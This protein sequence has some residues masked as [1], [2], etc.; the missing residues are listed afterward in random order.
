MAGALFF[1]RLLEDG[2]L[3]VEIAGKNKIY[4][5]YATCKN[6]FNRSF[7][8]VHKEEKSDKFYIPN[9]AGVVGYYNKGRNFYRNSLPLGVFSPTALDIT[10]KNKHIRLH[11]AC[12]IQSFINRGRNY[13]ESFSVLNVHDT[14]LIWLDFDKQHRD[15]V[16][17]QLKA[18]KDHV[19]SDID[20]KVEGSMSGNGAHVWFLAD[21][22][23][24]PYEKIYA[25]NEEEGTSKYKQT[26]R[27]KYLNALTTKIIDDLEK[28]IP[29]LK[30]DRR[31][32]KSHVAFCR[33]EV[34]S[35]NAH[36]KDK[37][38]QP[39]IFKNEVENPELLK[40]ED[41]EQLGL[42]AQI[43]IEETIKTK[44]ENYK[45]YVTKK[46]DT[47]FAEFSR[48]LDSDLFVLS[49]EI[50]DYSVCFLGVDPTC[51]SLY[52]KALYLLKSKLE[53]TKAIILENWNQ[54]KIYSLKKENLAIGV[55]GILSFFG[56]HGRKDLSPYIRR[57]FCYA[58]NVKKTAKYVY[59]KLTDRFTFM[60]ETI[61]GKSFFSADFLIENWWF[62]K[63]IVPTV[64][65]IADRMGNKQTNFAIQE[66]TPWLVWEVGMDEAIARLEAGLD[67]SCAK[68]KDIHKQDIRSYA[69]K[70]ERT[71]RAL[72]PIPT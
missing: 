18:N 63:K 24:I 59:K 42:Q 31:C 28:N 8:K 16:E 15:S 46:I 30:T 4:S 47:F 52:T 32:I 22:S 43:N 1:P 71:K 45:K 27:Y 2:K 21:L 48:M 11:P 17:A 3:L 34:Q 40:E 60:P 5:S 61:E 72:V 66:L 23:F 58:L 49:K 38:P 10:E 50:Q 13:L 55:D 33:R 57:I 64:R 14:V 54:N 69:K 6:A 25:K 19:L 39:I 62:K 44:D 9:V 68:H 26:A 36:F 70:I 37:K 29:T 35:L 65:E 20:Y 51:L 67:L 7:N 53:E 41:K 12:H 56:M